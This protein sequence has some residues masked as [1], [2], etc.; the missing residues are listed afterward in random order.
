MRTHPILAATI[1]AV[2]LSFIS[3]HAQGAERWQTPPSADRL[4]DDIKDLIE[5]GE[6]ERLARR[7][8]IRDLRGLVARYDWPWTRLLL[9]DSFADGDYTRNPAWTVHTGRFE[10]DRNVGLVT[11]QEVQ[12]RAKSGQSRQAEGNLGQQLLSSVLEQMSQPRQQQGRRRAEPDRSD[13]STRIK[14]T[15]AFDLRIEYRSRTDEGRIEFGPYSGK[16]D[17]GY[18]LVYLPNGSP[19]LAL[20]RFSAFGSGVV[21]VADE[22]T[23]PSGQGRELYIQW[24][25]SESGEMS[26]LF[27]GEEVIRA[28]DN[29]FTNGFDGLSISNLAGTHAFREI[30]VYGTS[31]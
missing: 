9:S 25:R 16:D 17:Q 19:P 1:A 28:Q 8:F 14:I 22:S 13:I 18:R 21:Q 15:N 10:V 2:T 20:V 5:K 30:T 26:I 7:S 11:T 24:L 12:H 6:R 31:Q 29:T 27:N 3:P 23:R 4:L